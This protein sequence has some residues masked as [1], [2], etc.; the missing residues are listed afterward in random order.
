[1]YLLYFQEN[2]VLSND[3][4]LETVKPE[5]DVIICLSVTK[6]IHLNFGDDGL[7]RFF[8]RIYRHLQPGGNLILEPQEWS[9]YYRKR[10][11]T[12]CFH[13]IQL[14]KLKIHE[15]INGILIKLGY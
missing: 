3:A 5:Y 12:V 7:K 13:L 11:L 4:L 2:Y 8:H 9:S 14:N 6:W 1:M 10:K 15:K